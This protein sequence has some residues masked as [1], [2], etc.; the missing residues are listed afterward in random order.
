MPA[1]QLNPAPLAPGTKLKLF[2]HFTSNVV[3]KGLASTLTAGQSATA[4]PLASAVIDP[5]A[6]GAIVGVGT[7][8]LYLDSFTVSAAVNPGAL[9]IPVTAAAPVFTHYAGDTVAVLIDPGAVVLAI[10]QPDRTPLSPPLT[11]VRVGP[12][13]YTAILT[14]NEGGRR[15]YFGEWIGTDN[16]DGVGQSVSQFSLAVD[17][18]ATA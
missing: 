12:G 6:A 10:R 7:G 3:E 18:D 9:S 17:P 1:P 4:I 15:P 16:G 5:I 8:S 11:P 2:A 14:V 13:V